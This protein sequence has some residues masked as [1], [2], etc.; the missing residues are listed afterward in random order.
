MH[1]K[2]LKAMQP[3]QQVLFR[4]RF[5]LADLYV[6][7]ERM[8]L[9][10]Y[11]SITSMLVGTFG[12]VVVCPVGSCQ[13]LEPWTRTCYRDQASKAAAGGTAYVAFWD[14]AHG[15]PLAL[16]MTPISPKEWPAGEE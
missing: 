14:C 11:I 5:C 7:S 10:A 9:T 3:T 8:A 1:S 4:N 15:M 13:A 6:S 16:R 12:E 2:T